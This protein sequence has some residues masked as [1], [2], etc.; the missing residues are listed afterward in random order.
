M[1]ICLFTPTFLPKVGG[2]EVVTDALA[3]EFQAQGHT[4]VVLAQGEPEE[5]TVPYRVC[6]YRKPRGLQWFPERTAKALARLHEAEQFD[7]FCVN[8]GHPTGYGAVRL[9][10]KL[11]VPVVVVSHGGDLYRTTKD[12][13]RPHIWK[14]IV[15]AYS[16]ADALVAISP[17]IEQLIREICPSPPSLRYIPNGIELEAFRAPAT[18]PADFTDERPFVLC[19][20]NL[21]ELK[22]FDDAIAAYGMARAQRA[23]ADTQLVVVG[24]GPLDAELRRQAV[25][26]GL[27]DHVRFVGRRTGNDKH[28][29]LQNCQFGLMPSIEEGHPI[30]GLE[31]LA[32][33]K[34]IVCTTNRA[35][36][37]MYDDGVNSFRV[38]P[39][40]RTALTA[41]VIRM[42]A[43]DRTAMGACCRERSEGYT[44]AQ[45]AS[46][47]LAFFGD[48]AAVSTAPSPERVLL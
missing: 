7:I 47:Y 9:G 10:K 35:F 22:G 37:H 4:P 28:W 31:F 41:A 14:R 11:G 5:L 46:R 19:L 34:P 1:K 23:L 15:H 32:C 3:R 39:K 40:D 29:F 45:V 48:I 44:W 26:L 18:R 38:E 21:N 17:Y 8:Y 42:A 43:S 2:T 12:R 30:V 6:W 16:H 20:G 25:E 24:D 33:G 27:A 36:D 13:R